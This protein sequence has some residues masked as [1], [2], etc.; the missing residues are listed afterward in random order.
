[1]A[2]REIRVDGDPCLRKE[3]KPVTE[4]TDRLKETIDDMLETMYD[5]SGVGLAAPQ[6]GILKQF[7]VADCNVGEDDEPMPMA[8]INPEII[9]AE[10][11]QTGTEGCLSL[12]GYQGV[13]TRA[14]HIRVR[15]FDIN[16][17]EQEMEAHGH[18]ARCIQHET[19]HLHGILYKDKVEGELEEV[20]P[21]E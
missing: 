1:M 17:E 16:M 11:E 21:E 14:E 13:V 12:P 4:M 6:I 20:D 15:F 19:D 3:C 7:F 10:G 9:F 8:F 2:I 18:W 5:A